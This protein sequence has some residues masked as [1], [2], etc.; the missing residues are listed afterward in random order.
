MSVSDIHLR[1]SKLGTHGLSHTEITPYNGYARH[2]KANFLIPEIH[3]VQNKHKITAIVPPRNSVVQS[4]FLNGSMV[5]FLLDRS[6]VSTLCNAYIRLEITNSTGAV[7]TFAPSPF[8][9]DRVEILDP[10]Q[11]I[12]STLTG[13]QLFLS[14]AFLSREEWTQ[15]AAY[16]TSNADYSTAGIDLANGAT[17]FYYI[18]IF[19]LFAAAKLH[20]AGLKGELTVRVHTASS[21][22]VLI[23]GTHPTVVNVQ[24][25]LKGF[26]EPADR[27][28]SR[29]LVYNGQTALKLPIFNFLS[30]KDIQTLAVSSTYTSVLSSIKGN[31][32]GLF[33][34]VR[35]GAITAANQGTYNAVASYDLQLSSGESLLG[36]AIRLHT[37]QKIEN[38][39]IFN[40]LF[41]QNKDWYFIPFS[42][43]PAGDYGTGS[44]SGYQVF[45]GT[46]KLI[47]N[48]NSTI[49]PGSFQIDVYALLAQHLHIE[50]GSIKLVQ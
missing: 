42:P 31:V 19:H 5:E 21:S 17:G 38:A 15:L 47:I 49:T 4:S 26:A 34:T 40:N 11:N 18:P 45:S 8:W 10:S 13:Q 23:A 6:Q 27:R 30:H 41:G 48:T 3:G 28:Q 44:S 22:T 16:M 43:D 1:A 2:P 25:Q 9:I 36:H 35:A 12:L 39:E 20:L 46:E 33:F 14:L 37:D 7:C 32:I 50:R 24:L 29:A